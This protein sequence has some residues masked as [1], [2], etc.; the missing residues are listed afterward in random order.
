VGAVCELV[1]TY[2]ESY[3][4]TNATEQEITNA[5]DRVCNVAPA[6][7][8]AQCTNLV[9]TYL[10]WIITQIVNGENGG[11]SLHLWHHSHAPH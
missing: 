4:S 10:T 1:V 7:L 8:A 11:T 5:L 2:A 9:A 6:Y 3:L